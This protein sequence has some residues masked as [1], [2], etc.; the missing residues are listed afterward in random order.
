MQDKINLT[1]SSIVAAALDLLDEVG[2][3]DLTTRR[4]AEKLQIRSPTL[5]WHFKNKRALLEAMAE[6]MMA[7]HIASP[8]PPGTDWRA[9]LLESGRS[10][11][12]A[13]LS[14]RDGARV[15]A[16][17]R[18]SL[19][20]LPSAEAK[21]ALLRAAGFSG[22]QALSVLLAVSRYTVGWVL[23]EQSLAGEH[24]GAPAAISAQTFPHMVEMFALA[25]TLP[26]DALF[27]AG[28]RMIIEGLAQ[29]GAVGRRDEA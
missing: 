12:R 19:R 16:M 1:R 29:D 8:P 11:R 4:L 3:D 27:E 24:T 26:P 9:M 2:M 25:E 5:Y 15:H 23:E 28:L 20:Q 14:H 17:A 21:V 7:E 13:M 22:V 6:E 18:P 10:F